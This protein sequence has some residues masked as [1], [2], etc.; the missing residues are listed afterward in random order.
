MHLWKQSWDGVTGT[1]AGPRTMEQAQTYLDAL[2]VVWTAEDEAV[3]DGLVPAGTTA[4]PNLIDT[5]CP[6]EGL[7]AS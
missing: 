4:V 5:I 6:V 3:F 2:D 7:P 1:I